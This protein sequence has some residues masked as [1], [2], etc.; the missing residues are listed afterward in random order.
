MDTS[1]ARRLTNEHLPWLIWALQLQKWTVEVSFGHVGSGRMSDNQRMGVCEAQPGQNLVAIT[2]DPEQHDS[3]QELIRTLRHELLHVFHADHDTLNRVIA[4][5]VNDE[6]ESAIGKLLDVCAEQIVRRIETM[7]DLG[8]RLDVTKMLARV[9]RREADRRSV[10]D[11]LLTPSQKRAERC[12]KK[13]TKKR[14]RS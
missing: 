14:R 6:A 3:E 4:Q 5:H 13:P 12:R 2:I 1:E 7:L 9:R 8:L 10:W 11:Q